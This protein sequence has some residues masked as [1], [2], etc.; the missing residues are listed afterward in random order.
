MRHFNVH[1]DAT[2]R[3]SL[4]DDHPF[5]TAAKD[6]DDFDYEEMRVIEG[7]QSVVGVLYT[8]DPQDPA[9]LAQVVFT[10]ATVEDVTDQVAE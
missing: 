5:V 4:P 6:S 7:A 9:A 8:T 10:D 3:V 2:V 1:I